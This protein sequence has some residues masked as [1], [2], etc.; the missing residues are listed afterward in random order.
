MKKN[1]PAKVASKFINNTNQNIF[2]TGK[3]GTGKTTFLR[4]I[5]KHTHK[6]AVVAA[7]TGI[8]A[9]NAGGVTLHSLFQLPF[10]SFIPDDFAS[11]YNEYLKL[12]TPS[13][14]M[15]QSK[16]NAQKR[17]LLKEMEL[18]IID[19]VSMLRADLLDAID[20]ILRAV[21]R[22]DKT[23][24]GIQILFIGDLLQLPPVVKDAEWSIL[25][26]YYKSAYF[27]EAQALKKD[28]IEIIELEKIYRQSDNTFI[29]ILNKLRNGTV[30]EH[31]VELLNGY[32]NPYYEELLEEQYIL[33]T[34]HN[35][36]ADELNKRS[37]QN[38]GDDSFTY[39]AKLWGEFNENNYPV[40]EELALKQGAQV[41]FIKND[42]TG[43]GQYFNGKIG[44]IETLREEEIVVYFED[45][46]RS[47]TVEEYIWENKRFTLDIN[48]NEVEEKVIGTFTQYPLKL[49]WAITIHKSQ[50]LTFERAI[51]DVRAAFAPGQVYVALSRLTSL[52]GLVLTGPFSNQ[53]LMP[54]K[55]V[56]AF[57]N[58]KKP[59]D[60]VVRILDA[61]TQKYL[62]EAS[63]NTFDF[64][65][66]QMT[67]AEHVGSYN[68]AEN[69]SNKQKHK[70]W[71]VDLAKEINRLSGV[72]ERFQRQLNSFFP[73]Q[74]DRQDGLNRRHLEK[75]LER[76]EAAKDYFVD[77]FEPIFAS[78]DEH[79]KL[80]RSQ[81][82]MTT[83]LKELKLL[84]G[85]IVSQK[86]RILKSV[87]HVRSVIDN[88]ELDNEALASIRSSDDNVQEVFKKAKKE[89][90]KLI[91]YNWYKE[92]KSVEEIAQLRDLKDGTIITHLS[93]FVEQGKIPVDELLDQA[94]LDRILALNDKLLEKTLNNF[95]NS[96]PADY[97]YQDIRLVLSHLKWKER[98]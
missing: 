33:L 92:G 37:L 80:V 2:L 15:R 35:R 4:N 25:K 86:R 11:N 46:D 32:Y 43:A 59:I 9:I 40:E 22:T 10:G 28:G 82:A 89:D 7:P 1:D 17:Q 76:V 90:T 91:T 71:A 36:T 70:S 34:T 41:M 79:I 5:I 60:E 95:K 58:T 26:D 42:P 8:A 14:L 19:E 62:I 24:G 30:E 38:I 20:T 12:S 87:L 44:R 29:S 51:L 81:K 93:H 23:F 83:Y 64:R 66:L 31:D 74:S 63:L 84:Y 98:K 56:V 97:S 67:L 52:D 72:A 61:S 6:K 16:L 88:V 27:F 68:K 39:S 85:S 57:G 78:Y 18:L 50:G 49:A 65:S 53:A 94:K 13:S 75:I 69:K 54:E 96:L 77:G 48:T 21:R 73:N 45:E 55:P 3:A 47:V